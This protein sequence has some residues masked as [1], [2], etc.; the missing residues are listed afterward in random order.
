MKATREKITDFM[1]RYF[2]SYSTIAQ[3]PTRNHQMT[4]YYAPDLLVS[5]YIGGEVAESDLEGFLVISSSHPGIQETL[6]PEQMVIDEAQGLVAVLVRGVF[7]AKASGEVIREMSFSAHYKL[8]LDEKET[9]KIEHLWLFAQ[10]APAGEKSLF[11]MYE[12]E[13]IEFFKDKDM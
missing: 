1:K 12:E 7:T 6:S 8:K 5:A 13:M 9:I 3:D 10:Y 11:E 4:Q 2:E